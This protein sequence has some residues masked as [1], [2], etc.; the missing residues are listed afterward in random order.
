LSFG[1]GY[2]N[3]QILILPPLKS[4]YKIGI[5]YMSIISY[6]LKNELKKELFKIKKLFFVKEWMKCFHARMNSKVHRVKNHK[7]ENF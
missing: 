2:S 7:F 4:D 1:I 5:T 3:I 6:L